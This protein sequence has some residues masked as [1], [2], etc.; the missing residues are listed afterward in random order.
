MTIA[1]IFGSSALNKQDYRKAE[2]NQEAWPLPSQPFVSLNDA[3]HL[4]T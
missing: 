3:D 2:I 4:K 1:S